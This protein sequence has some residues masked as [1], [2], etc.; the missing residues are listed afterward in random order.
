MGLSAMKPPPVV[1]SLLAFDK[2]DMFYNKL[3]NF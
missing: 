1:E 2:T 3:I